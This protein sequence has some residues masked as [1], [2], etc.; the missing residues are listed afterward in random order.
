M[1]SSARRGNRIPIQAAAYSVYLH[2]WGGRKAKTI[3]LRHTRCHEIFGNASL[4][5]VVLDPTLPLDEI[6]VNQNAVDS[7]EQ[8]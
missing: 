8:L 7:P 3:R 2:V 4:R 5:P 6:H 1:G